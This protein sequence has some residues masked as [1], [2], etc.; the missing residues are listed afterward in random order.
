MLS[1]DHA[2]V[3]HTS[4]AVST[5]CSWMDQPVPIQLSYQHHLGCKHSATASLWSDTG[6]GKDEGERA[7]WTRKVLSS[8]YSWEEGHR[9]STFIRAWLFFSHLFGHCS[10]EHKS[11]SDMAQQ[12]VMRNLLCLE[13]VTA[14][15]QS[16]A[17]HWTLG[18]VCWCGKKCK[19]LPG[20]TSG[21][22][23]SKFASFYS[24]PVT[25]SFLLLLQ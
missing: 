7:L 11:N 23:H 4:A 25:F 13:E 19:P 22:I 3:T 9:I 20:A 16:A 21:M 8:L 6:R 17:Q 5:C 12:I 15:C 18:C 1:P 14:G 10:T 24:T 2:S